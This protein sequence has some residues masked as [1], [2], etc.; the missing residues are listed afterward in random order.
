MRTRVPLVPLGEVPPRPYVAADARQF[1][2]ADDRERMGP[3][4]DTLA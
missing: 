3:D 2:V 1:A 4:D